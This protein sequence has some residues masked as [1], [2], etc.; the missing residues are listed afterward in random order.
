MRATIVSEL[1]ASQVS[2]AVLGR[3]WANLSGLATVGS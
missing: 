2:K 1:G 3:K